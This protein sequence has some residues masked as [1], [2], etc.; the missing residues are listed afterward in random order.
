MSQTELDGLYLLGL[1]RE[2]N[3][4]QEETPTTKNDNEDGNDENKYHL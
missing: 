3:V 1:Q 2:K 4:I